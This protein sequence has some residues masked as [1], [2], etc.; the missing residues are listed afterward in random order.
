MAKTKSTPAKKVM[1][2]NTPAKEQAAEIGKIATGE[3]KK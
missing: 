2:K 1:P 3:V